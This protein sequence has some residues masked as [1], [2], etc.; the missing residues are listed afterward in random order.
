M[1]PSELKIQKTRTVT[2]CLV[3]ILGDLAIAS[4]LSSAWP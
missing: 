2:G 1:N 3:V 4:S